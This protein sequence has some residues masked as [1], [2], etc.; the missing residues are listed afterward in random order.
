MRRVLE[1]EG[2]CSSDNQTVVV[3][4]LL[5]LLQIVSVQEGVLHGILV[6]GLEEHLPPSIVYFAVLFANGHTP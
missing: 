2:D 1:N 3:P 5:F 6:Q 4:Q